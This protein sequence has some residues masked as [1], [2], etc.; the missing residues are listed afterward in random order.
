M[1]ISPSVKFI[2]CA[3]PKTIP[4]KFTISSPAA[5]LAAV[6]ASRREQSASHIP[7]FESAVLVTVKVAAKAVLVSKK[8]NTSPKKIL[9]NLSIKTLL[10]FKKKF[11]LRFLS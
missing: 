1:M 3:E 4:S 11:N 7:S 9:A 6:T 10:N 8:T 2:V 5:L